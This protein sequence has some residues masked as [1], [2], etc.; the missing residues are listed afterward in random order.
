M[1]GTVVALRHLQIKRL[2]KFAW[3]CPQRIHELRTP[4]TACAYAETSQRRPTDGEMPGNFW[5]RPQALERLGR[6]PTVE[7]NIEL[8]RTG[9]AFDR[10]VRRYVKQCGA[11]RA[12]GGR[13]GYSNRHAV[14]DATVLANRTG[15]RR[16]S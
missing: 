7:F 14:P 13:E 5:N 15:S 3:V 11:P 8:Q 10:L 6:L 4:L 16:S 12:A 2:E 1:Q 9:S